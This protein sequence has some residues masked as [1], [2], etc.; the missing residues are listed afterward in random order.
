MTTRIR[1]TIDSKHI[2]G[3]PVEVDVDSITDAERLASP[4]KWWGATVTAVTL[5]EIEEPFELEEDP[6]WASWRE[7]S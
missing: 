4:L 6:R 5:H 7:Q 2:A 1:L 3:G